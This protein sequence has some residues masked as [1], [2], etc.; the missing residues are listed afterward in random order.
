MAPPRPPPPAL[1]APG[2]EGPVSILNQPICGPRS[3]RRRG[4][5]PYRHAH[6]EIDLVGLAQSPEGVPLLERFEALLSERSEVEAANLLRLTA[7]TLHA[8]SA[9]RFRWIDH[10]EVHP[11]GWLPPP[12]RKSRTT[13]GEPVGELLTSFEGGAWA[14]AATA[15]SFSVRLS[16]REG[17]HVDMVVRRV[18]RRRRHALS[19][20]LWGRW[21]REMVDDVTG[22]LA[23]RLPVAKSTLTKFQYA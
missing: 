23:S 2:L 5:R 12:I 11:G 14:S 18:H 1:S 22:S 15:R 4:S 9:R 3:K 7:V 13:T 21:T 10:W 19:L 20:D 17:N 8:L 16:D 6:I